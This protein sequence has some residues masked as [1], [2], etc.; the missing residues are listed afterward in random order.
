MAA[1]LYRYVRNLRGESLDAKCDTAT[2]PFSDVKASNAHCAS[3]QW[4]RDTSLSLALTDNETFLPEK[5]ITRGEAV[6]LLYRLHYQVRVA[7]YN[8]RKA[9]IATDINEHSWETR[10]ELVA[11]EI[12]K[13]SPDVIGLQEASDYQP[14]KDS[15]YINYCK[16]DDDERK[17]IRNDY[18]K[19]YGKDFI[20]AQ[21][22]SLMKYLP[23]YKPI[24]NSKYGLQILI[25]TATIEKVIATGLPKTCQLSSTDVGDK[26][27]TT[28][29]PDDVKYLFI[30]KL[31]AKYADK[32]FYFATTHL[33]TAT[34]DAK[35]N[36]GH[37]ENSATTVEARKAVRYLNSITGYTGTVF[38]VGDFG[39]KLEGKFTPHAKITTGNNDPNFTFQEA[40]KLAKDAGA[41]PV[42]QEYCTSFAKWKDPGDP[43][44]PKCGLMD[45]Y[46]RIYM[47]NVSI[48]TAWVNRPPFKPMPSD[49]S[50]VYATT[51]LPD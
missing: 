8:V 18:V 43:K 38:F 10:V 27:D 14:A 35:D 34:Y 30:A 13:A 32:E 36:Y 48:V 37:S 12:K 44:E 3:I 26:C 41:K 2:E 6:D 50:L 9:C 7:T 51:L 23:E 42:K 5:T 25:K 39:N 47:H 16:L 46:D 24:D 1:F 4:L 11:N 45:K 22:D 40:S 20:T 29:G 21:V 19:E 15:T 31:K 28:I 17:K 33:T 49:H